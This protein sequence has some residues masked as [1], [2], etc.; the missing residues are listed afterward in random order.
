V[1]YGWALAALTEEWSYYENMRMLFLS[2][3][4]ALYA[5]ALAVAGFITRIPALRFSAFGLFGLTVLK[6]FLLDLSSLELIY[7]II[8]LVAVGLIL[9]AVSYLYQRYRGRI[10]S[11]PR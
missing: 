7:R 10:D 1:R 2:L 4:W 5:V 8:S 11:S 3:F 9:L 6:V